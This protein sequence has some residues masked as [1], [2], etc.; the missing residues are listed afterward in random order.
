[1]TTDEPLIYTSR[2]NVPIASLKF[3]VHWIV[4]DDYIQ[5]IERY[6]AEDGEIVKEGA[7]VYSKRGVT[8]ECTVATI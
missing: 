6:R 4:N 1:M 2:G 5:V 8:G 7:H 3:E